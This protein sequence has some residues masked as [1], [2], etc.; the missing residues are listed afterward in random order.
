M[1]FVNVSFVCTAVSRG[2]VP[3]V[4]IYNLYCHIRL[5]GQIGSGPSIKYSSGLF[6]LRS[7]ILFPKGCRARWGHEGTSA[8][9]RTRVAVVP[10]P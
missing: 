6:F 1:R 4:Y 10:A 9:Q 5:H 7:L 2:R 3:G 8:D